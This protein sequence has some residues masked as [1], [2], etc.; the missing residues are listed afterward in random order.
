MCIAGSHGSRQYIL[1]WHDG[2][3]LR[4]CGIRRR[5][6]SQQRQ[7]LHLF[8][9]GHPCPSTES[10]RPLHPDGRTERRPDDDRPDIRHYRLE[11]DRKLR[12]NPRQ[13]IRW[14]AWLL[15]HHQQLQLRHRAYG[16]FDYRRHRTSHASWIRTDQ[17]AQ[18]MDLL[19]NGTYLRRGKLLYT[20]IIEYQC[21][22]ARR[23]AEDESRPTDHNTH[24]RHRALFACS[25]TQ[26]W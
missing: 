16:H 22:W 26:L 2:H 15:H 7:R 4:P 13:P 25:S 6:P 24:I 20:A 8:R 3:Q 11:A 23:H 12:G 19:A 1:Q 9:D 5:Q 17:D 10:G 14:Q 21:H 18:S